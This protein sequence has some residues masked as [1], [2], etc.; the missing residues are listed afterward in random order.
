VPSEGH[1]L[2]ARQIAG[3]GRDRYPT[4]KAQAEKVIIEAAELLGAITEHQNSRTHQ[5]NHGLADCVLVRSE[6]ADTA[7]ALYALGTKLNIDVI[8]AMRDLVDADTRRFA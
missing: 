8:D 1:A 3:H 6:L 2:S 4:P 5:R 7:L